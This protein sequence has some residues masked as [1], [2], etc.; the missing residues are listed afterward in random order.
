MVWRDLPALSDSLISDFVAYL[1]SETT[2]EPRNYQQYLAP[3]FS[4]AKE[5]GLQLPQSRDYL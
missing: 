4:K 1:H 3:V 2:I 5:A